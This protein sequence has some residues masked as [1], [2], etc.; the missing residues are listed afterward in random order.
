M[1]QTVITQAFE[2]L[3]AQEAA[4][5]GVLTLDEFVFASVPDLNITDPIDRTEGLPP[6]AQIVHRQSVSKTGMVNSNA[7]VYSVVLG[8]EVGDFEFNWVGL[9]N[10]ASGVVAMI[11]HAPSQK[12]IK[13]SSGQ[14]GN[15]LTRSFLMEYNGASQ[16]TQIITP[17]DTWQID[18]TA[19][20]NGVDERIRQENRD[21]YGQ[22]SF[23]DDGFLVS[24]AN[25]NYL[26][27]KG[28][29]YIEGL[30]AELLFDQAMAVAVRPSRI[31]V[32][33]C[34]RGTL[35][36]VWAPVT[37][38]IVA[39]SLVNYVTGDEQ[40]YVFAIAEVLADGSV[41]DLRQA[42]SL[43]Q[44]AE[45]VASPDTVLYFDKKSKLK[46][47]AI[48]EF[49]R[50][51]L[52]TPDAGGVLS[53]I[54][55]SDPGGSGNIGGLTKPVTWRGFAGGADPTGVTISDAAFQ[56]AV[57]MSFGYNPNP[58]AYST[59]SAPDIV[60]IRIPAGTY[61]ISSR[62]SP[63]GKLVV[64]MCDGGV[65]ID[66]PDFLCGKVVQQGFRH[67]AR[68][69]GTLDSAVAL[70]I[71]AN[72]GLG[73]PPAVQG[74]VSPVDLASVTERDAVG[75]YVDS[76]SLAPTLTVA[77]ATYTATTVVP[78][79]AV[80]VADLVKGMVIDTDNGYAGIL[81][82]WN[83]DGTMLTVG[84]GWYLSGSGNQTPGIPAAAGFRVNDITKIWALNANVV[85]TPE[86]NTKKAAGFELGLR[87]QKMN[88]TDPSHPTEYMWG[89]DVVGFGPYPASVGFMQRTGILRGFESSGASQEGFVVTDRGGVTPSTGFMVKC[90]SFQQIACAPDGENS[91]FK[92]TH[93][94][95]MD[96][97]GKAYP[98]TKSVR[99]R[100]GGLTDDWDVRIQS[101]GGNSGA[102]GGVMRLG[103]QFV[104]VS[105]GLRPQTTNSS[106][107]GTSTNAW[108]GGNTQTAFTV[109]SDARYKTEPLKITDA[110]LDAAEEVELVQYQII[111]R[112]E[113][114]GADGARWHFGVIAQEYAAAFA[115]HGLDARRFA[116]FCY[117]EWEDEYETF[118]LNE[119]A[120]TTRTIT[121][122]EPARVDVPV[123]LPDG[124]PV[125]D[126]EGNQVTMSVMH[127]TSV[128]VEVVEAD[129]PIYETRLVRKAG[130][131]YGI[132]YEEVL[133]L[134]A[135]KQRRNYERLQAR[136]EAL[137]NQLAS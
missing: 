36:S 78:A 18:F 3:K 110:M 54:G 58:I 63:K 112:V 41:N 65:F 121:A 109:L 137:E 37:K 47:S 84:G 51:M 9:L 80:S 24:G 106:P 8:A 125:M 108:S 46:K 2:E 89:H 101:V 52:A 127:M 6:A 48:S 34:W 117:D 100:S 21:V 126:S 104:E 129:A 123:S 62:I 133:I 93:T 132:R 73:K 45:L 31:W 74:I 68:T 113:E 12:K 30:R 19:R 95:D 33:V 29:A 16:Q 135:A 70:S 136:I 39:D 23:M 66:N 107:C 72:R 96:I 56:K 32:D 4:N 131:K 86:G 120:T 128:D 60:A 92:V 122:N 83:E 130:N 1:S 7:V 40:H 88:I 81:Q 124:T 119:G 97:G 53:G 105:G 59:I 44:M 50:E 61:K 115:R 22:A 26:V 77:S 76:G 17:A 35:T 91:A 71:S 67:N 43:A 111:D 27:K 57:D 118:I 94:G 64:W 11:V 10:K 55:L 5:G 15:V 49:I 103:A 102:G 82:S 38:L 13:T 90:N 134:E 114:K 116:F 87:N 98:G 69:H 20:L 25:G 75:L 79:V 42:S 99:F 28:V 14:Q 85:L